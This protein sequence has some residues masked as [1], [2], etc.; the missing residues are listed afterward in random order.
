M[1]TI[2]TTVGISL[3][4]PNKHGGNNP[5]DQALSNYLRHTDPVIASAETNSLSRILTEDD[6]IVF[7]YSQ[8]EKGKLCAEALCT[9]YESKGY[10]VKLQEIPNLTYTESS[11]KVK[12]LRSLVSTLIELVQKYKSGGSGEVLINATGGFKAEMAYA[13]LIGLLFNVPVFYIHEL[14]K[15]IIMMPAPPIGWDYSLIADHEEFFE[16]IT[17]DYRPTPEVTPRLNGLPEEIGFLLADE[18][19]FTS[20]SPAG[21]VFFQAFRE[22]Q[23]S[24]AYA[25]VLLSE[26]AKNTYENSNPA[27]QKLFDRTLRKLR[28]PQLRN[29]G[30]GQV[31]NCDCR[32]YPRGNRTERLF[33]FE[34]EDEHPHVCELALH[35]DESYEGLIKRGISKDTYS[36]FDIWND[37]LHS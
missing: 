2:L 20:L 32:V 26:N 5:D 18:E 14:F 23:V 3:I 31:G 21:E 6:A 19:G 15:D 12:G 28:D 8:T 13:N 29:S 30:S 9:H 33:W 17:D 37:P 25:P 24:Y 1:R 10:T 22:R 34:G 4:A 11:F 7:L 35:N 16:W 36:A 27:T